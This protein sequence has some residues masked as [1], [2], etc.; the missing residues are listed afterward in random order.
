MRGGTPGAGSLYRTD[1]DGTV[2]RALDGLTIVN[3]PAFTAAGTTM[4]LADTAAGTILRCR[5]DLVSGDLSGGPETFAQLRDGEGSLQEDALGSRT[6][7]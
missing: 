2:V 4:Y 3:G 1:A 5:V 6:P 7:G